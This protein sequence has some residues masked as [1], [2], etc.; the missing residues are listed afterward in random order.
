MFGL[1]VIASIELSA[2]EEQI[3]LLLRRTAH[4]S[5][6]IYLLI[7]VTRPLRQL[8]PSPVTRTMRDNRRYFGIVLAGSQTVHLALIIAFV[9][10]PEV[11][12]V[13][14]IVGG[15]AYALLYSM[16]ITSFD[17]PA[18]AIGPIAWRRLHKTGLYWNG[19]VFAVAL[20]PGVFKQPTEWAY[21]LFAALLVA[22][23]GIRL[24]AF[25]KQNP[26]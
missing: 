12:L 3:S 8:W 6:L 26:R 10:G 21:W 20:V 4:T 17:R 22:A 1:P 13:V 5:F 24:T 9:L 16:L 7:F 14:L 2:E 19:S 11:P 23:V 18:A 15:I 25:W